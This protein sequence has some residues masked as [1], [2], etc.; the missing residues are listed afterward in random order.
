MKKKIFII[1]LSM[2]MVISLTGCE[3][4]KVEDSKEKLEKTYEKYGSVEEK[5]VE[6]LVANFNTEVMVNE[7]TSLNPASPDYLTESDN[8]YWYGLIEGI[9]LVVVPKEYKGN[10]KNEIVDYMLI[11]VK[12]NSKYESDAKEY[13]KHLIKANNNELTESEIE[14][15]LD[16]AKSKSSTGKSAYNGKGITVGYLDK[17]NYYQYQVLRMYK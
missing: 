15:L 5:T 9:Y 16:E 2:V 6:M 3:K 17:S 14:T 4:S 7:G 13:A 11:Y 1:L 10:A 12:K 8:M